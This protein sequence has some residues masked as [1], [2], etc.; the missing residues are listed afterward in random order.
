MKITSLLVFEDIKVGTNYSNDSNKKWQ[1]SAFFCRPSEASGPFLVI[2]IIQVCVADSSARDEDEAIFGSDVLMFQK[3]SWWCETCDER[4]IMT[5]TPLAKACYFID[6]ISQWMKLHCIIMG[7]RAIDRWTCTAKC[8]QMWWHTNWMAPSMW[9]SNY[10]NS[11]MALSSGA[12]L[13]L[14]A[15]QISRCSSSP[16]RTISTEE[17]EPAQSN[18]QRCEPPIV[19]REETG[20][21]SF[22]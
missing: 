7:K 21:F 2:S 19:R 8:T 9:K 3:A 18:G 6:A 10:D 1:T 15:Q 16:L 17:A 12:T 4:T 13:F 5:S 14:D 22:R 20:S 11:E